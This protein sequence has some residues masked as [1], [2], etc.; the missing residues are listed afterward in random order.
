MRTEYINKH[1][2]LIAKR[3][4]VIL[5]TTKIRCNSTIITVLSSVKSK[6]SV[7]QGNTNM[8]RTAC[9]PQSIKTFLE[10]LRQGH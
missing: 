3:D 7:F 9:H 1:T 2:I 8:V 10:L 4:N 6:Q 5:R